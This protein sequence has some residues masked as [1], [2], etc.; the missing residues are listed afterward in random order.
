MKTKFDTC[1]FM[2]SFVH[3]WRGLRLA[4]KSERSFR[5][6]AFIGLLVAGVAMMMPLP[7]WQRISLLIVTTFVLVLELVNSCIERLVDLTRPRLDEQAK[8]VKDLM[9][10]AVFVTSIAAA[11]VGLVILGPV[12]LSVAVRL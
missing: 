1:E 7:W 3:A 2:R 4:F 5:V 10:G 6:Q 11:A 9:A 12:V 8:D